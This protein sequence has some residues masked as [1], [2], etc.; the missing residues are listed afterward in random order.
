MSHIQEPTNSAGLVTLFDHRPFFFCS[1]HDSAADDFFGCLDCWDDT[2]RLIARRAQERR[3]Y[4]IR[5][6]VREYFEAARKVEL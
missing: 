4:E 1:Q 5:Q 6:A 2:S 3:I